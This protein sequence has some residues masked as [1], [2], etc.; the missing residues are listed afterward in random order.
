MIILHFFYIM[1]FYLSLIFRWNLYFNFV[2]ALRWLKKKLLLLQ[3]TYIFLCLF[4]LQY[5][6]SINH[7]TI[8]CIYLKII[9]LFEANILIFF[10]ILIKKLKY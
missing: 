3:D 4:A 2:N 8:L 5:F 6:K 10:L 9:F 7:K 1:F